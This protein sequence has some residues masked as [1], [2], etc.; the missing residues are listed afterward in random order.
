MTR[1]DWI[2]LAAAVAGASALALAPLSPGAELG[3]TLA[4]G[5][6][7]IGAGTWFAWACWQW[8]RRRE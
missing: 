4:A 1:R 5:G 8:H 3:L 6:A 2:A 7:I